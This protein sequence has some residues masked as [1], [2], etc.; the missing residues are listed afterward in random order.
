MGNGVGR[1]AGGLESQGGWWGGKP[2]QRRAVPRAKRGL[3]LFVKK[4]KGVD[5]FKKHNL[6]IGQDFE[7][8]FFGQ[9]G[10]H[11]S[12]RGEEAFFVHSHTIHVTHVQYL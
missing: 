10:G 6:K 9:Q 5:S 7:G 4:F 2:R 3:K 11:F 1:V 8:R 12:S